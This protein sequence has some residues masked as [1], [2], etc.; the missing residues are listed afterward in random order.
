MKIEE[1]DLDFIEQLQKE[2]F[3][4]TDGDYDKIAAIIEILKMSCYRGVFQ[5]DLAEGAHLQGESK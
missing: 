3:D 1:S 4:Y 2:L 5:V